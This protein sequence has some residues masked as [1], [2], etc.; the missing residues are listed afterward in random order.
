MIP[1]HERRILEAH[2]RGIKLSKLALETR[3]L[4]EYE[5]SQLRELIKLRVRGVPLQYL[6]GTQAFY[7][8]DF[9][10]NTGVLIPRPETEGLVERVLS[11][12]PPPVPGAR[13]RGLELGTGSGCIALTLAL[14]RPDLWITAT[15]C[16]S[17]ALAVA[18]ENAAR[19]RVGNVDFLAV[20][21][22]PAEWQYGELPELDFLV[23]NP[24]YLVRADAIAADVLEHEPHQAL[25]VS[26]EDPIFF[27]RFLMDLMEH[28][29]KARG[30]GAFEIAEQRGG[31]IMEL[32]R[33]RGFGVEIFKDLAGRDRYAVVRKP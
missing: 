32:A 5:T 16:E 18:E 29:V 30:F 14:E 3:E 27:Y 1:P 21:E 31:A 25:F 22:S 11:L 17:A 6:T 15:E 8:R 20:S 26:E 4:N 12:L 24:P 2:V 23:S 19:L 7:G 13:L 33:S 9:Y 10:V 28:K